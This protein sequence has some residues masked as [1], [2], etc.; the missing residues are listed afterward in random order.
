MISALENLDQRT[1]ANLLARAAFSIEYEDPIGEETPDPAYDR[2]LQEVIA[3]VRRRAGLAPDD[4]SPRA[5]ELL[6]DVIDDELINLT[7]KTNVD[8]VLDNMAKKG[9]VPSDLY[10]LKIIDQVQ[11][12]YKRHWASEFDIISN[13]VKAA[14]QEQHFGPEEHGGEPTLISL[15][16]K[17]YTNKFP[18]RNFMMLVAGQRAGLTL[19]VHQAWRIYADD[20]DLKNA[21][22]LVD[23]LRRFCERFGLE[24]EVNGVRGKF[25][26]NVELANEETYVRQ[27]TILP[28]Y[29]ND[30]KGKKVEQ[31]IR[32]IMSNF[33]NH[34]PDGSVGSALTLAIDLEKYQANLTAHGWGES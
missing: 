15:F 31:Q 24:F 26:L 4:Q 11:D 19:H 28:V 2:V 21:K 29:K 9:E 20:I 16:A 1:A 7:G 27:I 34:R 22:D 8:T 17:S 6:S 30:G 32:Y 23:V 25:M 18:Y 12:I 13:T 5:I 10:V 14:D 3:E 33:T